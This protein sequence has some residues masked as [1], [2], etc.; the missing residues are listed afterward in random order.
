VTVG[1]CTTSGLKGQ[2]VAG[3]VAYDLDNQ[4]FLYVLAARLTNGASARYDNWAA[5]NPARGA[6]IDQIAL[7]MQYRF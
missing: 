4:T 7:G 3:G 1:D 6:D 5:G 2:M